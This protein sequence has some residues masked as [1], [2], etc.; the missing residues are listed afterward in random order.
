[1]PTSNWRCTV[2]QALA[3]PMAKQVQ[4]VARFTMSKGGGS[5][6][7]DPASAERTC[8]SSLWHHVCRYGDL[9]LAV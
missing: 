9:R 3:D 8:R 6:L 1:M 7:G 4:G 2:Y 5:A